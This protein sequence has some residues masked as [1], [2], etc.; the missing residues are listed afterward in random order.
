MERKFSLR[1]GPVS[2]NRIACFHR[3]NRTARAAPATRV[4][5]HWVVH[6]YSGLMHTHK[7]PSPRPLGWSRLSPPA[8]V[9]HTHSISRAAPLAP[10]LVATVLLQVVQ[11]HSSVLRRCATFSCA[12]SPFPRRWHPILLNPLI[13]RAYQ[14]ELGSP[15]SPALPTAPRPPPCPERFPFKTPRSNTP[16]TPGSPLYFRGE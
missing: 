1:T 10:L 9:L 14:P 12:L 15:L 8:R 4:E 13:R 11:A 3:S 2:S 5:R 16:C 7:D 6:Q